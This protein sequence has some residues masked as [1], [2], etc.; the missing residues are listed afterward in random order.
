MPSATAPIGSTEYDVVVVGAGFA[1]LYML[2]RLRQQGLSVRV[3]EAGSGVGGTWFWNRYPGARCDVESVDYQ[4]SFSDELL[5]AW[6]WSER[7][8]RQD[9]LLAYLNH[10]ADRFDLRPDIQLDTRVTRVVFD[11]DSQLW[12]VDTDGGERVTA[13]YVVM[14]TGCL[15]TPR[16]PAFAGLDTFQGDTHHTSTWP[17][18][19]VDF[20]GKRVAVIGTGSSGIQS[21]PVIAEQAEKLLVFQRTANYSVPAVNRPLKAEAQREGVEQFAERRRF[22]QGSFTGLTVPDTGKLALELTPEE[23]QAIYEERWQ[24][25]GLPIYGAFADLLVDERANE[26]AQE[27]FRAKIREKVTDRAVAEKLTPKGYP[28][29]GKR[30][31]VD[32][33][34]FETFNRNN[35]T[36]IDVNVQPI[37]RITPT[38]IL[39][40]DTE[41]AIDLIVFATGFDAMTGALSAIDLR[42][43]DG[44][45]LQDKWAEGPRTYL[46]IAVAGF[47][48]LFLVTGPGSPSVFS[49]MVVS[50]EQHVD[51]IADA[52]ARLRADGVRI[53]E[54]DQAAE[55]AWVEHVN[56]VAN[57]TLLP[58]ANSWYTGANVPGKPR[59]FMPYLGGVGAYRKRCDDIAAKDYDGFQLTA[60]P[61]T[62]PDAR[63]THMTASEPTDRTIVRRRFSMHTDGEL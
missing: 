51:W 60:W 21:I 40:G 50:I 39:A 62:K 3:F 54:A 59:I 19:G 56:L 57:S 12:Q 38:G 20:T 37:R 34:Y 61:P 53:I 26:T 10:V 33:G 15:S 43:R 11:E 4:Y 14:A 28:V 8:P 24:M 48:N 41:H 49:N 31:C 63:A 44:Q 2:H 32:T 36:L 22:A 58:R 27:F 25:G 9:E 52:I 6:E 7:Y 18:E 55:D 13:S 42:G 29:G 16:V 47:P 5:H 17:R 1:G 35:V 23:R 30:I 45:A 46:G